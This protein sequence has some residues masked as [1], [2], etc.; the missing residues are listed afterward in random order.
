MDDYGIKKYGISTTGN[1][2]R[3]IPAGSLIEKALIKKEGRLSRAGCL[4]VET[5]QRTGRSPHDKY[6]VDTPAVHDK[7]AWGKVNQPA[8]PICWMSIPQRLLT[9]AISL[10]VPSSLPS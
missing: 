7:I 1:V 5:G 9:N 8:S 3:N 10:I 6:V 2:F 4:C